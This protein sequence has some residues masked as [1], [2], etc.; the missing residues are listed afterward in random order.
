[1]GTKGKL[2]EV[3]P[4][5]TTDSDWAGAQTDRRRFVSGYIFTLAEG[6]ISWKSRKQTCVALSSNEAEYVAA[7]ETARQATWIRWLITDNGDVPPITFRGDN[8]GALT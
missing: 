8:V 7:S 4:C 1:M 6:P 5:Y 2:A 3:L